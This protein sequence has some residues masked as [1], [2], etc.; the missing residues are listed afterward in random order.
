MRS[1]RATRL[2]GGAT[3]VVQLPVVA[4]FCQLEFPKEF[5]GMWSCQV[6]TAVLPILL[7]NLGDEGLVTVVAGLLGGKVEDALNALR[8]GTV[9]GKSESIVVPAGFVG[10][11]LKSDN[12]GGELFIVAHLEVEEVLL[13]LHYS[14][15]YSKLTQELLCKGLPIGQY[16]AVG[17][18]L[19]QHHVVIKGDALQI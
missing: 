15:K 16:C 11:L 7:V 18:K 17:V 10:L 8:Q 9:K 19:E 1:S 2:G 13:G 3:L 5:Q 12:K 14:V 6:L 4:P